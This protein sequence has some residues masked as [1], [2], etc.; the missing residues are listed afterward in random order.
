MSE[1]E[2]NKWR[3]PGNNFTEDRGIDTPDMETFA[4]EPIASLARETCQNSIDAKQ[5]GKKALV[6][7]KTFSLKCDD[8]PGI[9]DIK[10]QTQ[11][12]L[13][14]Q[15][16][17]GKDY[18]TLMKINE[19]LK[20]D[21]VSCLRIS[22]F[23]T[24]G[25]GGV[26]SQERTPFFLLT[27]GSGLSD[28][29]GT[30]G[31]SKGIGKFASF[32]A[33]SINTVFYSTLS[34]A[35]EVGYLGICKLCSAKMDGKEENTIGIGY[36]GRDY[37]NSPILEQ[38]SLDSDFKR[39][40]EGTD[41]YI[42]AF[43]FNKDWK[44]EIITKILDSFISA[45]YFSE[46]EIKVDDIYVNKDTLK[47]IIESEYIDNRQ[48][49]SIKSQ[50]ILLTDPNVFKRSITIEDYG[51]IDVYV[52]AF[53]KE[54]S[55]LATYNCVMI[56]YP[57]MKIKENKR[58][59][60][61][62]CSAMCIIGDNNLN[63]ELRDIENPQHTDWE[64]KRIDDDAKKS[65]IINLIKTIREEI[66]NYAK[67]VL[68][69]N[70]SD[71]TDLEGAGEYLPGSDED[72][73]DG[74]KFEIDEK[75]IIAKKVKNKVKDFIGVV[76]D[77]DGNAV[78]P[79]IGSH[80]EGNDSPMPSGENEGSSGTAHDSDDEAGY[81][82]KGELEV[83][84]NVQLTGMKYTLMM[85]NKE[86]GEYIVAFNSLYSEKDCIL[87]IN[88]LDDSKQKYKINII[89]CIVNELEHSFSDNN[90]IHL[91]IEEGKTY[92]IKLKTDI[93]EYYACEVKMYANR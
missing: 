45:I 42:I 2:E 34:I 14:Y 32:V 92:K 50:F 21:E 56:R 24:K 77:E 60:Q 46:L 68:L 91:K 48:Y 73:G 78:Q 31:G 39:E 75:P 43:R 62:P 8:I 83:V 74:I 67:E 5:E 93:K 58:I 47:E 18:K 22:D 80:N 89:D 52:K 90:I 10:K 40:T 53:K 85:P 72:G 25:L 37:K 76:E 44:K 49:N 64:P 63:V 84:R 1:F 38:Y 36:Y 7:F 82:D 19:C 6:E 17:N 69:S 3:F 41:I 87:E 12:C 29:S 65:E 71:K 15:V 51:N 9:F 4:K 27:K 35:Q 79:D 81:D 26:D 13:D 70:E 61:I 16:E 66:N 88:Y 28:K 57:Y 86:T 54:E 20:Q 11:A 59:S 55:S 30:K 23:N 33:S